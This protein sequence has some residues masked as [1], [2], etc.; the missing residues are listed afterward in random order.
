MGWGRHGGGGESNKWWQI[1]LQV[2]NIYNVILDGGDVSIVAVMSFLR[3]TT[4]M[5]DC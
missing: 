2:K 3:I 4:K 1:V 5:V